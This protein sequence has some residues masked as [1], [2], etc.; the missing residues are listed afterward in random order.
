[1]AKLYKSLLFNT[2]VLY[3]RIE[4]LM[5]KKLNLAVICGGQ[6]A[7]HEISI[8]SAR[9]VVAALDI[10]KYQ[11]SVI[12]ITKSGQWFLLDSAPAFVAATD[13]CDIHLSLTSYPVTL[14]FGD[15]AKSILFIEDLARNLRFDVAFPVLHGTQ[16]E[17]GAMQGL[18]ELANIPYVG[19]GI[20]GS[21]ICMDKE[22][23][24][25]LL[26]AAGIPVAKWLT[27]AADE[28]NTINYETVVEKLGSPFFIKPAN[29]GS[30]VGISKIKSPA[31]FMPAITTALEY[32][33]KIL[34]EE[35]IL[36]R[37]IECSV[38]G[39][40]DPQA[41]LLGEII[42][43]HEF[44]TYEA[45]YL[46]PQ[47]A[48]LVIPAKLPE[49]LIIKIQEIAKKA[50]KV[51]NCEGMARIDFF[52]GTEGRIILNEA[53]T[54]PGFTQISMYPKLWEATGL[55]YQVLLDQLIVFAQDHFARN[56][57]LVKARKSPCYG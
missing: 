10:N 55:S 50:Y 13:P 45:K 40:G 8:I 2:P 32:D 47:G 46:D 37:E 28:I 51:L 14:A 15:S 35:Y 25:I 36:G 27:F 33:Y 39:N 22:I 23:S 41:S 56:R 5:N 1:M 30:S 29:T 21:A 18:L 26:H 57:I 12:Y 24:K 38:L 44:Y 7:E 48:E 42:T 19:S 43:R 49:S 4:N 6:S 31:E 17:D 3:L 9:N 53:N 34:F 16:G 11:V 54:I 52:V 20:L